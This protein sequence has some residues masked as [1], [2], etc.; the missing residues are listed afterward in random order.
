MNDRG[1]IYLARL[2]ECRRPETQKSFHY[3]ERL[4]RD[5]SLCGKTV[6]NVT[7]RWRWPSCLDS[8][9]WGNFLFLTF[10]CRLT[11]KCVSRKGDCD[12]AQG[13]SYPTSRGWPLVKGGSRR[14]VFS[15]SINKSC[16]WVLTLSISQSLEWQKGSTGITIRVIVLA[17]GCPTHVTVWEWVLTHNHIGP[18]LWIHAPQLC[19]STWQW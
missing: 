6:V 10:L 14:R 16:L 1:W 9:M 11:I 18:H 2:P 19:P 8:G 3:T 17:L 4:S 13:L 7:G 15:T 5:A 12:T